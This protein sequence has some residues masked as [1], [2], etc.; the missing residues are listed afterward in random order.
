MWF[1]GEHGGGEPDP[2]PLPAAGSEVGA[3]LG[4]DAQDPGIGAALT[5]AGADLLASSTHDWPQLAEQQLAFA[6]LTARSVGAPLARADWRYGSA[7]YGR[8]G[9]TLASAGTDLRRTLVV[10]E[11]ASAAPT[12][13]ARIGDAIG[14]GVFAVTLGLALAALAAPRLGL[15]GAPRA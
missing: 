15:R 3:L 5:E 1:L 2:E 14:W 12:P 6:R 4:L 7:I 11:V 10:A 8:D 13:Y 9:E